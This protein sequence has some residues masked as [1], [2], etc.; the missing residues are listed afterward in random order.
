MFEHLFSPGRIGTL[1]VRNRIVMAPMGVEIVDADGQ[2][3]APLAAYYEERARGGVGLII[4]EVCAMAYPRGANSAH[5]IGLSSDDFIPGLATITQAVHRH[6][7]AI[8]VQLVHHGKIS[9]L[10]TKQGRSVLVPSKPEWPGSMDMINDLSMDELGLMAAAAGDVAPMYEEATTDDLAGVVDDFAEAARRAR[11][12]GFDGVELHAAHGYLLSSFLSPAWN[13]RDDHYGGSLENRARLLCEVLTACKQRAGDDFPVWC[14]LDALEYRTPHGIELSDAIGAAEMAVTAGADAIH[15]S[16]YGDMTSATAFTEGTLPHAK[17]RHAPHARA[18]KAS[19]DVPV[20]AV[21]R[22]E[23]ATAD[24]LIGDGGADFVAMGRPLLA[25]PALAAKLAAGRP[26]DVRPCIYCYTCVAQPFFDRRVRCAVNPETA[27][28]ASVSVRLREPAPHSHRVVV[29]GGGPAGLEAASVAARRGHEVTLFEAS[30]TLGGSLRFAALVYQPNAELLI[31]LE[32]QVADLGVDVRTSTR[33]TPDEVA[34]C[35]PDTVIVA[36]GAGRERPDLAGVDAGHV[37]DGD[38]L[39][40]LLTGE[41][42]ESSAGK[43][44]RAGRLAAT[45]GRITG[46]T[47]RTDWLTRL[48]HHYMPVGRRVVVIGG[49][50]VGIELAEFLVDRDRQVTVLEEGPL[51]AAEM[52]HP[53]RWRVLHD[54][55]EHG[56]DLVAEAEVLEIEADTVRYSVAGAVQRVPADT[57]V[58][59]TGL[60]ARHDPADELRAAGFDPIEIGDATGVGYIEGA[61][62][63][64]FNAGFTLGDPEA[65]PV[66]LEHH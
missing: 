8:A 25:D 6:D 37:V 55:R 12:A 27:N 13:L 30:A 19:V 51:F 66:R 43:L 62:R 47:R 23:P 38:D 2:A 34:G 3:R 35:N 48:T 16:A 46:L 9:R 60:V 40:A 24:E 31:W 44:S 64:G 18:V 53:R 15:L 52:A 1:E 49:G 17:A 28:E 63:D 36:T 61:I 33:A 22:I 41:R 54:L 59:A 32:R 45:A 56:T 20:I 21:G 50:L 7:A 39:R 58:I 11:D 65:E 4:T 5:Q 14:R 42:T 10:D 57:V 26:Q 29:V